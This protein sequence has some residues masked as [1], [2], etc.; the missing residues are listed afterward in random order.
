MAP[1]PSPEHLP[2]SPSAQAAHGPVPAAEAWLPPGLPLAL[3]SV[4]VTKHAPGTLLIS[5]RSPS[6]RGWQRGCLEETE[7]HV[8]KLTSDGVEREEARKAR[9]GV[10]ALDFLLNRIILGEAITCCL[11]YVELYSVF[12]RPLLT[13]DKLCT[14]TNKFCVWFGTPLTPAAAPALACAPQA[15]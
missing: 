13:D 11:A 4:G 10:N 12:M 14:Y 5:K 6:G 7:W 15:P 2:L 9:S 1:P 3:A 8:F